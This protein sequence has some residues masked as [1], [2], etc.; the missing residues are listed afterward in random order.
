MA[1][2]WI[3]APMVRMVAVTVLLQLAG[4]PAI[5]ALPAADFAF[6]FTFGSCTLD[7]TTSLLTHDRAP[8]VQVPLTLAEDQLA[9]ISASLEEI[10]FFNYPSTF[11]GTPPGLTAYSINAAAPTYRM[12][13]QLGEKSHVVTWTDSTR[14]STDEAFRLRTVFDRLIS[15]IRA[16]PSYGT[17][18][19]QGADCP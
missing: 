17:M 10:G 7:T 15:F 18:T 11:I 9:A 12:S 13:V 5:T 6:Q 1:A 3:L 2:A 14:P 4:A 19:S 8:R 16:Q